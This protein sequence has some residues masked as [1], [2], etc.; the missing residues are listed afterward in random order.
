MN[1]QPQVIGAAMDGRELL[2]KAEELKD[3]PVA[4]SVQ[5]M[6]GYTVWMNR[7]RVFRGTVLDCS[8]DILPGYVYDDPVTFENDVEDW[9]G[10]D[11][12]KVREIL[13]QYRPFWRECLRIEGWTGVPPEAEA[14]IF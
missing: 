7:C 14:V 1:G 2:A 11:E 8:Q 5:D 13:E 10:G 6:D 9:C 3:L 4:V 12:E